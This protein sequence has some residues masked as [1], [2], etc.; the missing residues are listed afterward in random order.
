[1]RARRSFLLRAMATSPARYFFS[2]ASRSDA[3]L[4]AAS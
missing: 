4:G 2:L 1:M 3:Q